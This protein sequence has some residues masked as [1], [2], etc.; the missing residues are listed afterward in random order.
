M[1]ITATVTPGK[2]F[3]PGEKFDH[4][5]LNKLGKPVIDITGSVGAL[6]LAD[7][8]VTSAKIVDGAVSAPKM[9]VTEGRLITGN[10][11]NEG[12]E[13]TLA[14]AQ[15]VVGNASSVAKAMDVDAVT[16]DVEA[17][18][19]GSKLKLDIIAGAVDAAK[20][21]S[22]AVT[23]AKIADD[24]VTAAKIDINGATELTSVATDDE[25]LVS[26]ASASNAVKKAT[27]Q[28][29]VGGVARL[30]TSCGAVNGRDTFAGGWSGVPNSV[31]PG[32]Y[33]AL[34]SA[35]PQWVNGQAVVIGAPS[36]GLDAD[37]IYYVHRTTRDIRFFTSQDDAIAGSGASQISVTNTANVI[38]IYQAAVPGAAAGM[39]V[40]GSHNVRYILSTELQ[41]STGTPGGYQVHFT[42]A[43]TDTNYF[44]LVGCGSAA[45]SL[46]GSV[47]TYVNISYGLKATT[48]FTVVQP[49]GGTVQF[50]D[51]EFI[52]LGGTLS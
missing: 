27:I 34:D 50:W 24:A 3:G 40:F 20:L 14:E 37:T 30:L 52:V 47:N 21:A 39:A 5:E 29:L 8:S 26:D 19:D 7:N 49:V 28:N 16:G 1:A 6:S 9:T 36:H 25:V 17:S 2:Q 32:D 41:A 33:I 23:T 46:G 13:L 15:L 51:M 44:P 18:T 35:C 22:N 48:N 11:A 4:E 10:G 31:T 43:Y 38:T 12:T 42:T 45:S